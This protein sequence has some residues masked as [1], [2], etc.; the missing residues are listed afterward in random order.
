L[1]WGRQC[2]RRRL[3]SGGCHVIPISLLFM[4][5]IVAIQLFGYGFDSLVI[6]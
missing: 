1:N 5:E 6:L 2:S 3:L 4:F